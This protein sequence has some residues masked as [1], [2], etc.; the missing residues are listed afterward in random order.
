MGPQGKEGEDSNDREQCVG[1]V[2][3]ENCLEKDYLDAIG[4]KLYE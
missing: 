1:R 3:V 4:E 2:M